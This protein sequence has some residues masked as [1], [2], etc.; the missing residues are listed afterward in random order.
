MWTILR[1]SQPCQHIHTHSLQ[2]LFLH[3]GQ[4]HNI[5]TISSDVFNGIKDKRSSKVL[6]LD[7]NTSALCRWV[8]KCSQRILTQSHHLFLQKL[9]KNILHSHFRNKPQDILQVFSVQNKVTEHSSSLLTIHQGNPEQLISVNLQ[10]MQ[11]ET[12][13]GKFF[14]IMWETY[15]DHSSYK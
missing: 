13:Q 7:K 3:I 5:N 4:Y 10:I 15:P 9:N 12:F 1:L 11:E 2:C 8:I 14:Q 6:Q